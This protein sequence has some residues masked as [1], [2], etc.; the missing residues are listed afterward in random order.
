MMCSKRN[1]IPFIAAF[2]FIF[3]F[4]WVYHGILLE[5]MYA[6]TAH[7]WRPQEELDSMM[8][9][10]IGFH[11]LYTGLIAALY[12]FAA[13]ATMNKA[14]RLGLLLGAL[15]GFINAAAY[16]HMPM[17]GTLAVAW[18]VGALVQIPAACAIMFMVGKKCA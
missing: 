13:P 15:V 17:P 10:C 6:E 3:G 4:D 8:P 12:C 9:W 1:L 2:V 14:L 5:G 16:I 18:L 7:L 11:L